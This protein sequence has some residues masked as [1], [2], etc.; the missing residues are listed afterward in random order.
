MKKTLVFALAM[1]MV[2]GFAGMA[3]AGVSGSAHDLASGSNMAG[4]PYALG[5]GTNQICVFCHHPH[6][7]AAPDGGATVKNSLLWN[8][9]D[10]SALSYDT[11]SQSGSMNTTGGVGTALTSSNAPQSFLCMACHD[12]TIGTNSLVTVPGDSLTNITAAYNLTAGAALG[13]TL[14]DDHPVNITWPLDDVANGSMV[15]NNASDTVVG[16]VSGNNYPLFS[17]VM[18]CG[19][20]HDVHAGDNSASADI[21]FMRGDTVGSEICMDCH[22]DK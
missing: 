8:M 6:R 22:I 5:T 17:G 19:T 10:F 13:T 3:F 16:D 21:G 18:Q 1:V 20:C 14:A 7:G 12:G 11:Y 4:V 9:N 2:L 15:S